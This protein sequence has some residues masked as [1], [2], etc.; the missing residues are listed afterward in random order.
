ME[1]VNVYPLRADTLPYFIKLYH[2]MK[3]LNW[4]KSSERK[5]F[6][7]L[8]KKGKKFL[9][10]KGLVPYSN[11]R[12]ELK[13][14][15]ILVYMLND[16]LGQG[17]SGPI[18]HNNTAYIKFIGK[19]K[20][21]D[22]DHPVFYVADLFIAENYKFDAARFVQI[23]V[24][25][26][27]SGSRVLCKAETKTL[28]EQLSTMGF[29]C[30]KGKEGSM[31]EFSDEESIGTSM[32]I[33]G[34]FGDAFRWAFGSSKLDYKSL[35]WDVVH[36]DIL[37]YFVAEV[38]NEEPTYEDAMG[39]VETFQ[40]IYNFKLKVIYDTDLFGT[41]FGNDKAR[42]LFSHLKLLDIH[43]MIIPG[44]GIK[45]M[46][47]TTVTSE[48]DIKDWLVRGSPTRFRDLE[49]LK[50]Q[51]TRYNTFG[52]AW[53]LPSLH[54]FVASGAGNDDMMISGQTMSGLIVSPNSIVQGILDR[55]G[56]HL[57]KI[58][59]SFPSYSN[60]GRPIVFGESRKYKNLETLYLGNL[61]ITRSRFDGRTFPMLQSLTVDSARFLDRV[62]FG[63]FPNLLSL[64]MKVNGRIGYGGIPEFNI[65]LYPSVQF[66]SLNFLTPIT[67]TNI[68]E[69]KEEEEEEGEE[70]EEEE[71]DPKP[72]VVKILYVQGQHA[73]GVLGTH[74]IVFNNL[75]MLLVSRVILST[76][77]DVL[78]DLP[79]LKYLVLY[80]G[81]I[82]II[83]NGRWKDSIQVFL[84]GLGP[85]SK[86]PIIEFGG[87]VGM[88]KVSV[89]V[90][91]ISVWDTPTKNAFKN[92]VHKRV[93]RKARLPR[94]KLDMKLLTMTNINTIAL[95][96]K[97]GLDF[98]S[99]YNSLRA[100]DYSTLNTADQMKGMFFR[101][102]WT[103]HDA[104]LVGTVGLVFAGIGIGIIAGHWELARRLGAMVMGNLVRSS[105]ATKAWNFAHEGAQRV[106][107]T[108]YYAVHQLRRMVGIGENVGKK[109]NEDEEEDEDY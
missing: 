54:T 5:G 38:N 28:Q 52:I 6:K 3:M 84:P 13:D 67:F 77:R 16:F 68:P 93:F 63:E 31:M 21:K 36:H 91:E 100:V 72:N 47:I 73:A 25:F 40:T 22:W 51:Q 94:N 32:R 9:S 24:D 1:D 29:V 7:H 17:K 97:N 58:S 74:Q 60:D 55:E 64:S 11:L 37:S 82:V 35:P 81:S 103:Y 15:N 46:F 104:I 75:E 92:S 96:N 70:E 23:A 33:G 83:D 41:Y 4:I 89:I 61:S 56:S 109:C 108:N 85:F 8:L 19:E 80:N 69:K 102:Y 18:V 106:F 101:G 78:S 50:I 12:K 2:N 99:A 87:L 30:V 14:E 20:T 71:K 88:E 62:T 42:S 76:S 79:K 57:R 86:F 105:L 34:L 48:N 53:H 95:L 98:L 27:P 10:A 66:L 65:A 59:F 90:T 26:L 45:S 39:T 43:G 49:F 107:L 44:D